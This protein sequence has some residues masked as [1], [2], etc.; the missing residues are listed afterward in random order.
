[1]ST[2]PADM[3]PRYTRLYLLGRNLYF[4]GALA[5]EIRHRVEEENNR[6]DSPLLPEEVE[7]VWRRA[8]QIAGRL[9]R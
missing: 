1:M 5:T 6:L 4:D 7:Y 9:R 3:D 2:I 8:A